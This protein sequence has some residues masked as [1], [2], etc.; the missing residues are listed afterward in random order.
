MARGSRRPSPAASHPNPSHSSA[1]AH[2][3]PAALPPAPVQPKEPGLMVQMASTAAGVAAGSTVGHV[4]G[5]AIT[6]ALS[7]GSTSTPE[8]P[9]PAYQEAST[10][11]CLYQV[12]QFLDC[13]TTQNDL[14]L[15]E[16]FN[17]ALKQCKYSNAE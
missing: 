11:P 15:C 13:A 9:K 17:E 6:G 8:S 4:L 5:H 12:R 1:P 10:D 2:S 3:T 16:S 14:H 7:E